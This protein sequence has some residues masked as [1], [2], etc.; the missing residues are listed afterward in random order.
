[1]IVA[2]TEPILEVH[3][4]YPVESAI[5]KLV[6]FKV[7]TAALNMQCNDLHKQLISS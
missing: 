3:I 5:Q 7:E 6:L 2:L 1:M 4:H